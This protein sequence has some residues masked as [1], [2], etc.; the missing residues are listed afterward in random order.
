MSFRT[1]LAMERMDAQSAPVLEG[2]EQDTR[3]LNSITI[4]TVEIRDEDASRAI[5]KPVGRYVT[6]MTPPFYSAEELS[7]EE[8]NLITEE[9]ASFIPAD[10]LVLVSVYVWISVVFSSSTMKD[11]VLPSELS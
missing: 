1:D 6:I 3:Q 2:I 11:T 8:L 5:E 7:D 4:S 9:I 10:G